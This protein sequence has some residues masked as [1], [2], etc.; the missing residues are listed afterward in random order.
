MFKKLMMNSGCLYKEVVNE[1]SSGLKS[2]LIPEYTN[3]ALK[4]KVFLENL[5]F[6]S[7]VQFTILHK[8]IWQVEFPQ[9][10][11]IQNL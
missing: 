3:D 11:K 8:S 7:T 2:Y 9:N 4:K 5:E 10:W 1:M 6:Q